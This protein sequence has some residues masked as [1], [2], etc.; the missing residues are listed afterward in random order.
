MKQKKR[1][2]LLLSCISLI[3]SL[4]IINDTYAK[5]L[6]S[7][8]GNANIAIA[9]W[10]ILVNN[11]DI[12]NNPEITESITPILIE[13]EHI[14]PGFIAPTTEGYFDI[15][16]DSKDVDVSF[17]YTITST[18]KEEDCVKDLIIT[19][20]SLNNGDIIPINNNTPISNN[21]LYKDNIET[22]NIRIYIKWIDGEN[23]TM[24]NTE[25]TLTTIDETCQGKINVKLNFLQIPK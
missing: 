5:Y 13:N 10:R 25:D 15:I 9:R 14:K 6:N 24:N 7:A 16:I 22:T 1:I 8:N 21:I 17:Q 2:I 11:Q 18:T 19:G 3:I 23:E 4:F 20:Y 12:R